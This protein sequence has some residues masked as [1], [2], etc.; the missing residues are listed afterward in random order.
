MPP[1]GLK[2]GTPEM[3]D[4][5]KSLRDKRTGNRTSK[6]GKGIMKDLYNK[7]KDYLIEQGK[8]QLLNV[9]EKGADVLKEKVK[10]K[11]RGEG[12]FGDVARYGLN[13]GLDVIP[14]P[15]IARD[16]GKLVGNELIKKTGLGM[17][18]KK[19]RVRKNKTLGNGLMPAGSY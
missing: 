11:I 3:R 6:K 10:R 2:A 7:G 14:I 12:I 9:V 4:Y 13:A 5:M 17:S 19:V 16:V 1:K 8:Q 18:E 15:G